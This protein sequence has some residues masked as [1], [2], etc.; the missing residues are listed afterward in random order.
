MTDTYEK[1]IKPD[2]DNIFFW[3][4]NTVTKERK[5]AVE[6]EG[7]KSFI[8]NSHNHHSSS[9]R[10]K[11]IQDIQ[12]PEIV[13]I[14]YNYIKN[15]YLHKTGG[16]VHFYKDGILLITNGNP[17]HYHTLELINYLE[18][19]QEKSHSCYYSSFHLN[20]QT[21]YTS[22]GDIPNFLKL[23]DKINIYVVFTKAHKNKA[24]KISINNN[25][26][27][28][29]LIE[30]L[31]GPY[32]EGYD[33]QRYQ[34]MFNALP[35]KILNEYLNAQAIS[36]E[37][38]SSKDF[39]EKEKNKVDVKDFQ[40]DIGNFSKEVLLRSSYY[41]AITLKVS[42]LVSMLMT[43]AKDPNQRWGKIVEGNEADPKDI[44]ELTYK[45]FKGTDMTS[46]Y[47][48]T[49]RL[50]KIVDEAD[51]T[52]A[53][54]RTAYDGILF[55]NQKITTTMFEGGGFTEGEVSYHLLQFMALLLFTQEGTYIPNVGRI[56][57]TKATKVDCFAFWKNTNNFN[58]L[59]GCLEKDQFP[60]ILDKGVI[61]NEQPINDYYGKILDKSTDNII[62]HPKETLEFDPETRQQIKEILN[63]AMDQSTGL[64]IPYNACV[65]IKDDPIFKYIRFIEYE[66][67]IAMF[68][69]DSN[70]RYLFELFLK[71]ERDFKYWLFNSGTVYDEKI[72]K[73]SALIYLKLASCIRDWKVLIERDSTMKYRGKRIPNGSNSDKKRICY[74]PITK[75]KR[76]PNRE[77]QK[78]E[79]VFFDE[80]RK[81]S[82][83]R[84][85]H[86]RL[87]QDGHKASKFQLILANKLN[88]PVPPNHTFVNGC[89]WGVKTM[90]RKEKIYR[91]KSLNNLF[92]VSDYDVEKV[93][94]IHE[95]GAAGF[96]ERMEEYVKKLGWNVI[97]R[98]NY[99]GGIDIRAIKEFKEGSV[100]KLLVQ[101]KHWKKPIGPDVIRELIGAAELEESEHEKVLMVITSS[102][103][104]IG[105]RKAA[106]EKN[107]ELVDGDDLLK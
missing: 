21:Y 105:A 34:G 78:K 100:K 35:E 44:V 42:I 88:I 37:M 4:G 58:L 53:G 63:E 67:A 85:A 30:R 49:K 29:S 99:D 64:W 101:C 62:Q 9:V 103:F 27:I 22:Y 54:H 19:P 97:K 93:E 95:L 12:V 98:N 80:N 25:K 33:I 73:S 39:L 107:I 18:T 70:E 96:E 8:E 3:L 87:L 76:N 71:E 24:F 38:I 79:R 17:H 94:E 14:D 28:K 2:T 7:V 65:E 102:V 68:I 72:D 41:S 47:E 1:E 56:D 15:I 46:G 36:D 69:C 75:Y 60:L 43:V 86:V 66:K 50:F 16:K 31:K 20:A 13:D 74:L 6:T 23:G 77:Q 5:I 84:R 57:I 61:I 92:Y 91:S 90:S 89:D 48:I 106:E 82:G 10:D 104:T 40:K 45:L 51:I 55:A 11:H 81:F 59:Y 83:E 32:G 26:N 52:V